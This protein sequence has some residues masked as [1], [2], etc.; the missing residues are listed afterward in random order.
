M[1]AN[2]AKV[3]LFQWFSC[4]KTKNRRLNNVT[5]PTP[6]LLLFELAKGATAVRPKMH[7]EQI[8]VAVVRK[9]AEEIYEDAAGNDNGVTRTLPSEVKPHRLASL[10]KQR[11]ASLGMQRPESEINCSICDKPVAIETA[12]TDELGRAAHDE[13]YLLKVG[14]GPDRN[15]AQGSEPVPATQATSPRTAF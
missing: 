14:I 7:F 12:K 10:R 4:S 6:S 15:S 2:L 13:C 5:R 8:P 9:I 1:K 11:K 3:A